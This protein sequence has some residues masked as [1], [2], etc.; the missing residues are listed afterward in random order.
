MAFTLNNNQ[1]NNQ[2]QNL[3]LSV[4]SVDSSLPHTK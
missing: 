4:E 2:N 1:L 3:V